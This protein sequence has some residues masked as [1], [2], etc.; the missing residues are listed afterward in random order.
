MA[1][2][3]TLYCNGITC[4]DVSLKYAITEENGNFTRK[5][6]DDKLGDYTDSCEYTEDDNSNEFCDDYISYY[7]GTGDDWDY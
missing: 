5:V 2:P 7:N 3:F 4:S 1:G 6:K